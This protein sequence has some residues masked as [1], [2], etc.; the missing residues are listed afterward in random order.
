LNERSNDEFEILR[1]LLTAKTTEHDAVVRRLA[2]TEPRVLTQEALISGL[3]L[4]INSLDNYTINLRIYGK[5]E[6][7]GEDLTRFVLDWLDIFVPMD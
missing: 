7:G 5:Q 1:E 6:E 3:Q 2:I 4:R